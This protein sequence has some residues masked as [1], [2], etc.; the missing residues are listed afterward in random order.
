MSARKQSRKWNLTINEPIEKGWSHEKLNNTLQEIASMVYFC[1][2]DEV[3]ENETFHTHIYFVTKNPKP[4]TTVKN[5][6]PEAHIESPDG[7]SQQNRDYI[8][9][10]GAKFNKNPETGE[11]DYT[12]S[13]GKKH[14]GTHYDSSN[15]EWGELPQERQGART[16][17]ADL[18]EMIKDGYSDFEIMETNPNYMMNLEK[19]ERARQ[20]YRDSLFS[21]SKRDVETT[22][23]WGVTGAGKTRYVVEKYGYS[24]I[25]R[26]TDYSHP[27]DS[28]K[29]QDVILFE[30]F[31]SSL[32][33]S[34]MLKYLDIHPCELPS[35]YFNKTACYTKIYFCT[36]IDLR[37]Q[38]R[39]V[40]QEE[41]ETWLSFLRRIN[42]VSVMVDGRSMTFP[43]EEYLDDNWFFLNNDDLD[44]IP[45]EHDFEQMEM[46]V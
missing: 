35:R 1:M 28:Y 15:E 18:Y 22:Y 26:V 16:D 13:Q 5:F 34:D 7:T 4:F 20:T 43:T 6:F 42:Y 45:F 3:G 33:I 40:Q 36:N 44:G 27:F 17:I 39:H 23:I 31:R 9:K 10:D 30:E 14:A 37:D 24:N 2:G 11:Y 32:P 25:Y 21:D 41:K 46:S 38:Y 12:D 29:G 19:I 8:F